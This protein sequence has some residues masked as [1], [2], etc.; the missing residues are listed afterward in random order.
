MSNSGLSWSG[1]GIAALA[2][3]DL[4]ASVAWYRDVMGCEVVFQPPGAGWCEVSS[5]VTG[6]LIGLQQ[7]GEFAGAVGGAT[8]ML[9]VEDVAAVRAELEGRGV[10]FQGETLTIPGMVSMATFVDPTGNAMKV[11]QDLSG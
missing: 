6:L 10:E 1:R 2:V 4:A 5:P 7:V 9:E 8:L 3:T 11:Y